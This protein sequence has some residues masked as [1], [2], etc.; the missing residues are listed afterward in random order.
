MKGYR[1]TECGTGFSSSNDEMPPSPNWDD[2]HVCTLV[3]VPHK[4]NENGGGK[5]R[6]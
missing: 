1:C 4:F 5:E 2:G 3:E 6:S